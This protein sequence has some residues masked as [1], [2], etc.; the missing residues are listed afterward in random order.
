MNFTKGTHSDEI[1]FVQD[2][3]VHVQA[4]I[5]ILVD[6]GDI[7]APIVTKEDG[8]NEVTD[9]RLELTME[10]RIYLSGAIC[11]KVGVVSA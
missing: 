1:T 4:A 6:A 7:L 3:A 10:L 5:N 9:A 8:T 2:V 11:A